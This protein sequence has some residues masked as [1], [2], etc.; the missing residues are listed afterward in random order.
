MQKNMQVSN[1][2]YVSSGKFSGLNGQ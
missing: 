1:G 2:H